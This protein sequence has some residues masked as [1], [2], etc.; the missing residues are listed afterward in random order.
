MEIIK[1]LRVGSDVM[2]L[3]VVDNELF[4]GLGNKT[5]CVI[6]I[7]SLSIKANVQMNEVVQKFI[8]VPGSY[9]NYLICF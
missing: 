6:D 7:P 8:L 1:V 2:A 4:C 5:I 3:Q 9:D